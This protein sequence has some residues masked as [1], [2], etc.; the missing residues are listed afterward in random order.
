[1]CVNKVWE[2]DIIFIAHT[3]Q[4]TT[5][6][7]RCGQCVWRGKFAYIVVC[8]L[9][10]RPRLRSWTMLSSF[11]LCTTRSSFIVWRVSEMHS[12][13]HTRTRVDSF[14]LNTRRQQSFEKL[15]VCRRLLKFMHF[16]WVDE[17]W[18]RQRKL[19]I[20]NAYRERT[21]WHV[22]ASKIA[23]GW[24]TH[25]AR[26]TTRTC[27]SVSNTMNDVPGVKIL[28]CLPRAVNFT[29]YLSEKFSIS[30]IFCFAHIR[31]TIPT[32]H[33]YYN[34]SDA[35]AQCSHIL[36]TRATVNARRTRARFL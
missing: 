16:V 12:T 24:L 19:G 30:D 26:V 3:Q 1:M 4:I 33:K 35:R 10:H 2:N 18:S 20:P 29:S 23:C 7:S 11:T 6:G 17:R 8:G 27:S 14:I 34:C 25:D 21:L 22:C 31:C 15:T 32:S 28:N 13:A 5:H 9:V 36:F